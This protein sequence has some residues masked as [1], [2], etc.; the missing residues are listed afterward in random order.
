M[1]RSNSHKF[2]RFTILKKYALILAHARLIQFWIH[3]V[4]IL[5]YFFLVPHV[6]RTH[7]F[8]VHCSRATCPHRVDEAKCTETEMQL[9]LCLLLRFCRK[10]LDGVAPGGGRICILRAVHAVQIVQAVTRYDFP[11]HDIKNCHDLLLPPPPR[12]RILFP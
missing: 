10:F 1:S 11:C 6:F 8:S 12:T 5:I 4:Y 7:I 2:T 3:F 9:I